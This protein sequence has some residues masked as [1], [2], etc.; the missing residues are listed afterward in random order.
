M[1]RIIISKSNRICGYA[2]DDIFINSYLIKYLISDSIVDVNNKAKSFT[3]RKE[4]LRMFGV[5]TYQ[6][7]FIK[8]ASLGFHLN[9]II[10]VPCKY[11]DINAE[12]VSI[13]FNMARDL[14]IRRVSLYMCID[15]S[16]FK[17]VAY[18]MLNRNMFFYNDLHIFIIECIKKSEGYGTKIIKQLKN[19]QKNLDGLS[20]VTAIDFWKSVGAVI[21][22]NNHFTV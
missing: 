22:N 12:D 21:E 4:N 11:E 13:L 8:L 16:I 2:L 18:L 7:V 20:A 9:D 14:R 17:P 19:L 1:L 10:F 15:T 5:D 3:M 6:E